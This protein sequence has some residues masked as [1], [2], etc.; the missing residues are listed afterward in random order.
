MSKTDYVSVPQM[1]VPTD[2]GG[3][4]WSGWTAQV[5]LMWLALSGFG[6]AESLSP[7]V[8]NQNHARAGVLRDGILS[9]RLEIAKGEWHPKADDGIAPSVYAFG[10][11][12]HALQNPGS[13]IRVPQ[14]TELHVSCTMPSP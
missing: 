10:E 6:F 12:G 9:V 14:G 7:I 11:T 4:P 3:Y 1:A 2:D 5:L 8:A 13:L